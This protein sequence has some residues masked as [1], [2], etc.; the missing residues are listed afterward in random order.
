[1]LSA[2]AGAQALKQLVEARAI[3]PLDSMKLPSEYKQA[4]NAVVHQ[5]IMTDPDRAFYYKLVLA[6]GPSENLQGSS[7]RGWPMGSFARSKAS[8]FLA[9]CA[10]DRLRQ[11]GERR[12]VDRLSQP[13]RVVLIGLTVLK[14]LYIFLKGCTT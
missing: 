9:R 11:P 8:W 13:F 1:M 2:T 5:L 14:D 3:K 10:R 12:D 6:G 4:R 7:G